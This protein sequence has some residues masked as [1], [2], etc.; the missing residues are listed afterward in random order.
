MY[1]KFVPECGYQN[2]REYRAAMEEWLATLDAD[3][4][5]TLSFAQDARLGGARQL[6]RQWFA[7]LDSHYLGRAWAR[8]SSDERTFAILVPENIDTNLHYHCLMRLPSR[9]QTEDIKDRA[10]TLQRLWRRLVPRGTC[11]VELIYDLPGLARYVAKQ[12]VRPGYSQHF[13][14]ASEF[15]IGSEKTHG[16]PATG[17]SEPGID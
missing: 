17:S 14:M 5:V 10:A 16:P 2:R 7:R 13:L 12:V 8:R 11:D 6:L 9:G 1:R 3:L 15:H 4:F